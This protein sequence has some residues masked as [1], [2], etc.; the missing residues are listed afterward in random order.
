MGGNLTLCSSGHAPRRRSD[1]R[2]LGSSFSLQ[3]PKTASRLGARPP[4][5]STTVCT[6]R[7]IC[8]R[9]ACSPRA[10]ID[11]TCTND[12]QATAHARETQAPAQV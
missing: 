8:R 2:T 12:A 6:Q 1:T 9:G 7:S 10:G 3:Q 5:S 11:A 4:P